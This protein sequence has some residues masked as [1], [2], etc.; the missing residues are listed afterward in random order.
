MTLY[1]FTYFDSGGRI[2]SFGSADG[3][4]RWGVDPA[5]TASVSVAPEGAYT[6][7][8]TSATRSQRTFINS[9]PFEVTPG[10]RF[11]MSIKARISPDSAGSGTISVI[12][13]RET[14]VS[15]TSLLFQPA[16]I[17]LGSAVTAADGSYRIRYATPAGRHLLRAQYE[18]SAQYWPAQAESMLSQ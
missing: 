12:F 6:A 15:R 7:M 10:S 14:E 11:S 13:L 2:G 3:W 1:S 17:K 5:G 8:H 16:T 18:G 9:M 4:T